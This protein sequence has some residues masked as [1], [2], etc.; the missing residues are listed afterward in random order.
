MGVTARPTAQQNYIQRKRNAARREA[1]EESI[2][3]KGH[4]ASA[5]DALSQLT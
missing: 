4:A 1:A 2:A 3:D 5:E